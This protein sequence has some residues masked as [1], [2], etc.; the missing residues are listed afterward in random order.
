MEWDDDGNFDHDSPE[1]LKW[2]LEQHPYLPSDPS[3][4]PI[5]CIQEPG[6]SSFEIKR[7]RLY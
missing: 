7:S 5:E 3:K 6:T 4:R 2:Y 1:A